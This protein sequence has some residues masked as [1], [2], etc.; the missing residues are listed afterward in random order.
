[1]KLDKFSVWIIR[2]WE[3]GTGN[4]ELGTGNWELGTGNWELGTGNWELGTGNSLS[5]C[6]PFSANLYGINEFV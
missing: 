5:A 4:W 3:L 1:L 2:N 6:E